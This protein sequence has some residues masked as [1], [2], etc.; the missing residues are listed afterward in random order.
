M[1]KKFY[2]EDHQQVNKERSQTWKNVATFIGGLTMA[3]L[4]REETSVVT[5]L[6]DHKSDTRL[7]TLLERVTGLANRDNLMEQNLTELPFAYS[8]PACVCTKEKK[9]QFIDCCYVSNK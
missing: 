9:K 2:V 3:M 4:S 1:F 7:I 6:D 5:F 8:I